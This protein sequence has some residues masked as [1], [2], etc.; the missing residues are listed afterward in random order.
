MDPSEYLKDVPDFPKPGIVFKDI[1]PL[2]ADPHAF[3]AVIE[4]MAAPF[5]D[6]GITAVA[7]IESRG[8]I[9]APPIAQLLN[10]GFV[11]L[12]KPG[13]LPGE[14]IGV[15]YELEYGTDRLELVAGLISETDRV[16]VVDDV[17]ATGGTL[18]AACTLISS[19]GAQVAGACVL[20][21][22]VKLNGRSKLPD[23]SLHA[24]I[25]VN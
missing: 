23:V 14:V 18:R 5:L 4:R 11:M 20:V 1:S 6:D 22:L 19:V 8:F 24:Q 16:L 13:K 7:G 25:E 3:A 2:L 9:F 21:D 10:S 15:D 17:L 12:R